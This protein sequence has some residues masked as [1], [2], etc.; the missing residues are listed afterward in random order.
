MAWTVA[1]P[2][3]LLA[4]VMSMRLILP[5]YNFSFFSQMPGNLL[6]VLRKPD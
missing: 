5:P 3:P 2:I 6:L 4:P 1:S